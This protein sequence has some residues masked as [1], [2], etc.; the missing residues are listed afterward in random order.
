MVMSC[1]FKPCYFN[2]MHLILA[3]RKNR[4]ILPVTLLLCGLSNNVWAATYFEDFSEGLPG[5]RWTYGATYG[6]EIEVT[7]GKLDM[8]DPVINEF[9]TNEA[10]LLVPVVDPSFGLI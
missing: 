4:L 1:V 5:T 7:E 8:S 3:L 9:A 10:T 6:G 2:L